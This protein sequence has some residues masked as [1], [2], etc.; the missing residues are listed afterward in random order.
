[1]LVFT[2]ALFPSLF[3][4]RVAMSWV[5]IQPVQLLTRLAWALNKE[6]GIQDE[7]EID[8]IQTAT[9]HKPHHYPSARHCKN[10]L[11]STGMYFDI[12]AEC[13]H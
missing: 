8:V 7:G 3:L 5:F 11:F 2:F 9:F 12:I 4:A 10:N 1:M 13:G 6:K